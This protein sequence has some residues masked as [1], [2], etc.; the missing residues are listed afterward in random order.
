VTTTTTT[1]TTT[2]AP[3]PAVNHR[4]SIRILAVRFIG[5]RVY[6]RMRICDDSHRRLSIIERDSRGGVPSYIRR[7]RTL[8]APS[9]CST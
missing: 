8:S 1:T 6:T 4:P 7:F 5:I 2:T 9:P 3:H